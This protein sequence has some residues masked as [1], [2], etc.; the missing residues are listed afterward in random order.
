VAALAKLI[1][2]DALVEPSQ[3]LIRLHPSHF[4]DKPRIFAEE[5]ER[6]FA[7]EKQY[8]NVHVVKPVALGGSLGYYGG[9]DMDEKS[10]MMEYSDVLVTVYS[11]MVVETAVHDTPVVAAVIDIPGGW[12][13]PKKY[14]LSLKKIGNWPT[15]KR[16]RDAKAGRVA[17]NERELCEVINLYLKN[18]SLDSAE[19]RKFIEDE[20]TFTDAT[21][22]KRTAEYIL[23]VLEG[24]KHQ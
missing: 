8:P 12:N 15:H 4:Q 19:R 2:S 9:E 13:K 3:L 1:S 11:T 20:I 14:S 23:K 6:I 5:R 7:L 17:S 22:G 10:S 21:S 18:P 24:S 16:F